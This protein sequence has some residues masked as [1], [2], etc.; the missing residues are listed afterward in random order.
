MP[1]PIRPT[2]NGLFM[3]ARWISNSE[4]GMYRRTTHHGPLLLSIMPPHFGIFVAFHGQLLTI[5]RPR[6]N[7]A[8]H[9]QRIR[10]HG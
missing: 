9:H 3:D 10:G 5:M 7:S 8:N 1:A 4:T 2:R 6:P